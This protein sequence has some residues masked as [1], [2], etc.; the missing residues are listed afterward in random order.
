MKEKPSEAAT[1]TAAA[2]AARIVYR[3]A[4]FYVHNVRY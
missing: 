3:C 4:G 1:A 2:A